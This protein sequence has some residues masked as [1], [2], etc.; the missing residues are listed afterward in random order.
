M[1]LFKHDNSLL[2]KFVRAV[3]SVPTR[4]N[5]IQLSGIWIGFPYERAGSIMA[6]PSATIDC[7]YT[8]SFK[9]SSQ[10]M[11]MANDADSA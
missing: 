9:E 7:S 4:L 1:Q 3:E 5:D 10:S 8:S 2:K 6:I 11:F